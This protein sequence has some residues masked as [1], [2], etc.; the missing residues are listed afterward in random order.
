MTKT[1]ILQAALK[2]GNRNTPPEPERHDEPAK[3]T[4]QAEGQGRAPSRQGKDNVSAWLPSAYQTS[5]RLVHAQTGKKKQEL[6]AEALNDLFAKYDV[7]QVR[8]D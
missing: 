6:L 7:P 4:T 1:S 5:L 3:A 8:D 2:S